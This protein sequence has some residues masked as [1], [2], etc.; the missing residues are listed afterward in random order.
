ATRAARLRLWT[1]FLPS[2]WHQAAASPVYNRLE[3][4][5]PGHDLME[6]LHVKGPVQA[7]SR[8]HPH[9][10]EK[11]SRGRGPLARAARAGKDLDPK[12]HQAREGPPQATADRPQGL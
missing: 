3:A 8:Q 10:R 1:L 5:S 2:L 4:S 7:D 12:L 9:Y 11:Y 6:V